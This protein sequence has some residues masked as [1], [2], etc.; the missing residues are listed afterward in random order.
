[1]TDAKCTD[2]MGREIHVGDVIVYARASGGRTPDIGIGKVLDILPS[3]KYGR[4]GWKMSVSSLHGGN[5]KGFL[6][7]GNSKWDEKRLTKV[8][9]NYPNRCIVMNNIPMELR[10]MFLDL[11]NDNAS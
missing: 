11:E 4:E 6:Y 9:L 1:M 2:K 3:N 10:K 7:E 8:T 5:Y